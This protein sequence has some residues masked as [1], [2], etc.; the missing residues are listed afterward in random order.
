[1]SP[2][3][4]ARLRAFASDALFSLFAAD[5]VCP[6]ISSQEL[7][8]RLIAA[9]PLTP[10]ARPP[11]RLTDLAPFERTLR[12]LARD[13]DHGALYIQDL[14]AGASGAPAR[15]GLIVVDVQLGRA[16]RPASGIVRKRKRVAADSDAD[17]AAGSP[18]PEGADVLADAD[19]G[20]PPGEAHTNGPKLGDLPIELKEIYALLQRPTAKSRLL[21]EQVL[22]LSRPITFVD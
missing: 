21:A 3:V 12:A 6:P 5:K 13:W 20:A 10:G 16:A 22:G 4:D 11:F 8:T 19:D 1:M 7:L 14:Q 9:T 15:G 17:S 2:D 18:P